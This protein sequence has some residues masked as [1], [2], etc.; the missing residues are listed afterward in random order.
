MEARDRVGGRVWTLHEGFIGG[1]HAEAGGDLIDDGQDEIQHLASALGLTLTPILSGGFAF[2]RTPAAGPVPQPV[3]RSGSV[4]AKLAEPLAPLLRAYRLAE[5]R[6][7][8]GIAA[9]IGRVSVAAWLEEIRAEEEVRAIVRGLRGFFLAD[10]ED[11]SLLAL[12]DQL[13]EAPGLGRTYR[14]QGGNA[15]LPAALAARLGDRVLLRTVLTAVIQDGDRVRARVRHADGSESDLLGEYLVVTIPAPLIKVVYFDPPLPPE[16]HE[17]IATLRYGPVTKTLL[18][19][20]RRFWLRPQSPK[21]F[22]SELPI[23][24]FWDGNEEQ[25]GVHGI[26]SLMAG[27]SASRETQELIKEGGMDRIVR[28]LDW[29]GA[30]QAELLASR[31]VSWEDD[32]WALGGYAYFDPAFDPALRPWL[33]RPHGRVLFAGEHTSMRWQG[34]MNGAVESGLRAAAEVRLLAGVSGPGAALGG[35]PPGTG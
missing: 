6:W 28:F 4:W 22:G 14:I 8:S 29:L 11:L 32:P 35:E 9:A 17:A 21:A 25:A 23:G 7:D 5:R 30:D 27:A 34:Y 13:S 24:A 3:I 33:V 10:P 1:Q 20:D 2:V 26:L 18:Q 16:Q 31:V 15:C 19:F 12:V